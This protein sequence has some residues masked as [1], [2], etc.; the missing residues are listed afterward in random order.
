VWTWFHRKDHR[1]KMKIGNGDVKKISK[2]LRVTGTG[3]ITANVLKVIGTVNVI[4]QYATL[5][6][7]V[8]LNNATGVYADVYDGTASLDLTADGAVL[9]GMVVGA[10]FTKDKDSSEVYTVSN[11][12]QVRK[13]EVTAE[14]DIGKPFTITQKKDTDTFIRFHLTTTDN[15]VDF[16]MEVVF[17]YEVL[18]PGATLV[19]L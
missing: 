6:N 1:G 3:S 19:F 13:T 14:A 15:P 16:T 4:S 5:T 17:K 7:V 10:F 11:A 8:T 9:S 12:D 18:S 2:S